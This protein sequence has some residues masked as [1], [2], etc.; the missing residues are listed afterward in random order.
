MGAINQAVLA[1]L[2]FSIGSLS[3]GAWL[4]HRMKTALRNREAELA[5]EKMPPG[6]ERVGESM[7]KLRAIDPGHASPEVKKAPPGSCCCDGAIV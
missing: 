6:A 1:A 5:M 7:R 2:V 3:Y 4:R